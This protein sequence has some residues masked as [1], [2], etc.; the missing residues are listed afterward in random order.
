MDVSDDYIFPATGVYAVRIQIEGN[1]Y[2]GVCNVGFKPTFHD[3]N[4]N[5]RPSKYI[6][7]ISSVIFMGQKSL[8]N[9][10]KDCEAN[11]NFQGLEELV[12]SN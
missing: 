9:G 4:L 12:A 11:R 10:I 2:K 7:L 6:F 1:W 3:D 5:F 8:W